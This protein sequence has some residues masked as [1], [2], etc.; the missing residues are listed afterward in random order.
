MVMLFA[1]YSL[2]FGKGDHTT[3]IDIYSCIY[4]ILHSEAHTW[5]NTLL[6]EHKTFQLKKKK[7]LNNQQNLV[8]I[9]HTLNI[10]RLL[11]GRMSVG[12]SSKNEE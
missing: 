9:S 8:E 4:V 1:F 7:K 6:S 10:A 3:Y 5:L 11:D 12:E 2:V